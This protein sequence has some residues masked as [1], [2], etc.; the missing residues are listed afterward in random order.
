MVIPHTREQAQAERRS[1]TVRGN[2]LGR[3]FAAFALTICIGINAGF[4]LNAARERDLAIAAAQLSATN[5]AESLGEQASE[6]FDG[7][8]ASLRT[9]A[10][11]VSSSGTAGLPARKR[12][13]FTMRVLIAS[14]PRIFRIIVFDEH[15]RHVVSNYSLSG[16]GERKV[17]DRPYFVYHRDHRDGGVYISGPGRNRH[18]KTW[19]M[20]AT[21]RIN[22]PDGSFAGV[23]LAAISLDLFDRSY[24]SV[25]V[26][27]R[28][29]ITLLSEDGIILTRTPRAFIGH[30]FHDSAVFSEPYKSLRSGWFVRPSHLDG[31]TRL[32]AF[33]RLPNYPV[34]I[35]VALAESD[36][37][38]SWWSSTRI[39]L[40]VHT[41]IVMMIAGTG[42][43]LWLQIGLRKLA[44]E[45]FG[46]LA[47]HDALTGLANRRLFDEVLHREWQSASRNRQSLA[48][49]MIDVDHFKAY[50]DTYGHE[51][52]DKA[53]IRIAQTIGDNGVRAG[54]LAA[55]YGGEEFVVILAAAELRA[56]AQV[57]E[58]IRAA[59][60]ALV[61]VHTGAEN[62]MVSVSIG[63]AAIVPI[64]FGDPSALVKSADRALY[65]AKRGGRNRVSDV[66][67]YD[68]AAPTT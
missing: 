24:A 67:G 32:Y 12:I 25:N 47:L 59:V 61:I 44:E 64:P 17:G 18:D 6:A 49:L 26:G 33:R 41:V 66:C 14:L 39:N 9:I 15:G 65:D 63:V 51:E 53:L 19:V 50:N 3:W 55:R 54:D 2:T 7:A 56:A 43:A 62:G 13:Q 57:A 37:L 20:W 34:L 68:A 28:G 29:S 35:Q 11:L 1:R 46:R 52:G 8:D 58:R 31:V 36:Y 48:L 30:R 21:R 42:W 45:N 16:D 27:R 10:N 5:L 23:A 22:H 38:S 60:S 4:A 40:S